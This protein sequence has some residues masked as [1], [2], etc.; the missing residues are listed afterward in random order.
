MPVFKL[1]AKTGAGLQELV[2]FMLA[3]RGKRFI[4]AAV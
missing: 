4:P 2:E 3:A 1:S